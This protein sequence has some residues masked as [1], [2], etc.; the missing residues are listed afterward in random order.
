MSC[1]VFSVSQ[2]CPIATRRTHTPRRCKVRSPKFGRD[3][4]RYSALERCGS[5][6]P[7]IHKSLATQATSGFKEAAPRC[8]RRGW[9]RYRIQAGVEMSS[10]VAK[11]AKPAPSMQAWPMANGRDELRPHGAC[12]VTE[13][14]QELLDA[15]F[16]CQLNQ[17]TRHDFHVAT[18]PKWR[19]ESFR[20]RGFWLGCRHGVPKSTEWGDTGHGEFRAAS[21]SLSVG[22]RSGEW[23]AEGMI[24]VL[25]RTE[26]SARDLAL[27]F[28][29]G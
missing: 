23:F 22:V 13:G 9:R 6:C 5:S 20:P 4:S 16:L 24:K 10:Q 12:Q 26:R 19:R 28:G 2:A 1:P 21:D 17:R 7:S 27:I 18:T 15:A 3:R 25:A 29:S 8:W 14:N 11:P